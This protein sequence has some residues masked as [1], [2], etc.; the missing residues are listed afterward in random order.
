MRPRRARAFAVAAALGAVLVTLVSVPGRWYGV[1]QTDS[2]VFSPP[3]FTPLW[4]SRTV[5]PVLAT[6]A[7]VCLVLGFVGLVL[8]DRPVAGR[9]RRWG[10][11]GAVLGLVGT[12][13]GLLGILSLGTGQGAASGV[14]LGLGSLLI[15]AIG[16][17]V[18]VPSLLSLAVGYAKTPRPL[19]GY[20]FAALVVVTPVVQFFV[21][22]PSMVVPF[23]L[24]WLAVARDLWLHPEPLARAAD[25]AENGE[26]A[27]SETSV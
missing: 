12:V 24:V 13:A 20:A 21:P 18:L 22:G 9:W 10:G 5:M 25:E 16:L 11:I 7:G 14:V 8:R 15:G 26:E 6:I 27:D 3:P 23:A 19:L 4:V 2:Y 17:V 1:P